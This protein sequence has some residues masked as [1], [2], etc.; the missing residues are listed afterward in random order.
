MSSEPSPTAAPELPAATGD[1]YGRAPV[2]HAAL[3]IAKGLG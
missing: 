3:D 1:A 2:R